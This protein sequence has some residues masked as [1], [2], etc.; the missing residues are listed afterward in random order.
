VK[1][2]LIYYVICQLSRERD[3]FSFFQAGRGRVDH[4]SPGGHASTS[5]PPYSQARHT[6]INI[7][8]YS[9]ECHLKVLSPVEPGPLLS[10][11]GKALARQRSVDPQLTT[12]GLR[13]LDA[14][15]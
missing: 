5:V 7:D 15:R 9:P 2:V 6:G 14:E 12:S 11:A 13:Y 8:E 10:E 3:P 1:N 4:L